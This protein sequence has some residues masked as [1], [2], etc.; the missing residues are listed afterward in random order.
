MRSPIV[1]VFLL[2]ALMLGGVL[3][4]SWSYLRDEYFKSQETKL[5][6]H[7]IAL[8]IIGLTLFAIGTATTQEAMKSNSIVFTFANVFYLG[9]IATQL[10]FCVSLRKPVSKKSIYL[11]ILGIV[12]FGI[13]F[14][15]L[16]GSGNFVGRVLEVASIICILLVMQLYQLQKVLRVQSSLQ[17]KFLFIFTLLELVSVILRLVVA[18]LQVNPVLTID[19]IPM[20][21]MAVTWFNLS[22]NVLS[23][24]TMLGFWSERSAARQVEA[25]IENERISAL[26]DERERLIGSL[27][28][29]NKS[30]A[31][32][33]LSASLA[34]ELNQPIGAS[35]INLF[36]LR[37]V[38]TG[39]GIHDDAIEEIISRIELDNQRSGDIVAALHSIFKQESVITSRI[40]IAEALN[41]VVHLVQGECIRLG[42]AL[43]VHIDDALINANRVE[44]QQVFLNLL[45]NAI[46]ALK[47][48]QQTEQKSIWL[49]CMKHSD[50]VQVLISDNGPGIS[51]QLAPRIFDLFETSKKAGMGLG[52][53]LSQYCIQRID[54]E[55][56]YAPRVGGGSEFVVDIPL[57]RD[58]AQ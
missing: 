24:L 26:L 31:T 47:T 36:T 37:R 14:E 5:W 15:Y 10:L 53:W 56:S 34:H 30:A 19:S 57:K 25:S 32:G 48:N 8:A 3:M 45:N 11:F 7:S 52:L 43:E 23:Y 58:I 16:R 22:F 18:A 41:S 42:I 1:L 51:E 38:L 44:L 54:G 28:A 13:H 6:I 40:S 21:L 29:A 27:L 4:S 39:R 50:S 49:R 46:D 35:R 17:L 2:F 33:A 12:I 55:I 20:S 9:S